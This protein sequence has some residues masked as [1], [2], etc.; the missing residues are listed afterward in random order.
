MG[1]NHIGEIKQ[2][3]EIVQPDVAVIT[4][5]SHAHI[6][7]FGSLEGVAGAKAEI[8]SGL[9][10]DGT[11]VINADDSFA[12]FWQ[13]YCQG[14]NEHSCSQ[15]SDHAEQQ[16]NIKILTYGLDKPADISADYK[17]QTDGIELTIKTPIGKKTVQLKQFG[18]H[19]VY[20]AW[21][22]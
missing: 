21:L 2:L 4:N 5:A 7:G 15:E 9:E 11:A 6:E 1:A 19:N 12:D 13:N 18:K 3:V 16:D 14:L 10:S 22:Q 20:N 8:Y 17:Q